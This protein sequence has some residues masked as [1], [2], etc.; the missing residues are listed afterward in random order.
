MKLVCFNMI[1]ERDL[2]RKQVLCGH[3][4]ITGLKEYRGIDILCPRCGANGKKADRVSDNWDGKGDS[5]ITFLNAPL[6]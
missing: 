4:L 1:E 6:L 3:V 5:I 2:N